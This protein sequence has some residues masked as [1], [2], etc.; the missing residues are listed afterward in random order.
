MHITITEERANDLADLVED[1]IE[2]E[3]FLGDVEDAEHIIYLWQEESQKPGW[4]QPPGW[5]ATEIEDKAGMRL[6]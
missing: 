1:S 4:M 3:E 5:L 2:A 6:P